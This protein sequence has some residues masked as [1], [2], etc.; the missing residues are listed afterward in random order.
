MK[1]I[2]LVFITVLLITSFG[3]ASKDYVR[4]QIDPLVDRISKLDAQ[5]AAIEKRI[6]SIESKVATLEEKIGDV[7]KESQEAMKAAN[8]AK[9]LA[10]D[11]MQAANEAKAMSQRKPLK[12]VAIGQMLRWRKQKLLQIELKMQRSELARHLSCSNRN[13]TCTRG[14]RIKIFSSPVEIVRSYC[15][16]YLLPNGKQLKIHWARPQGIRTLYI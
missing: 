10:Q 14:W 12:I 9:A 4:Q 1:K 6:S 11:A 8:E 13:N 16:L 15:P 2:L 5:Y 3:C 7:R